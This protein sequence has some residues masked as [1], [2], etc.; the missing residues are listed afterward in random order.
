MTYY[1]VLEISETA[2]E[3]VVRVAYKALAKKYHPDVFCGDAKEAEEK[4]K[5][6]NV[7]F[8]VLS[9]SKKRKQYDDYLRNKRNAPTLHQRTD[10]NVNHPPRKSKKVKKEFKYPSSTKSGLIIG[11]LL[12][13]IL[14]QQIGTY[15]EHPQLF[16]VAIL[17]GIVEFCFTCVISM[18]APILIAIIKSNI[19]PKKIKIVCALN[20]IAVYCI[21]LVLYVCEV[22]PAMFIGWVVAVLYYFVNK[23]IVL[24]IN[25]HSF[26]K[27]AAIRTVL[28]TVAILVFAVV[29][30]AI[31][32][33]SSIQRSSADNQLSNNTFQNKETL[34]VAVEEDFAPFSYIEDNE[35]IGIHI[36]ISNELARRLGCD[37]KFV[38][39]NFDELIGGV[40]DGKYD[41]ALGVY[42]T[43]ERE[44]LV[45][46]S[47]PYFE[48]MCVVFRGESFSEYSK[49]KV[50][51]D[52]M[53]EDGSVNSVISK[54][55]SNLSGTKRT[56]YYMDIVGELYSLKEYGKCAVVRIISFENKEPAEYIY[57]QMKLANFDAKEIIAIMD[58][59]ET[60]GHI[61]EPGYY[62]KEVDSWC[63]NPNRKEGDVAIIK[64]DYGY[65]VCF[66]TA[67][68]EK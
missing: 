53:I 45:M 10:E 14:C 61:I 20:S 58:Y 29:G 2:S 8:E 68:F 66:I 37:V 52:R 25:K 30:G 64:T 60:V 55:I 38:S 41:I 7:A 57:N 15:S 12:F 44:E 59:N 51:L 65:T 1:D 3:E 23:H 39:A 48:E 22:I 31:L 63:F 32:A 5:Q 4:M 54:Y 21:S 34:I 67:L 40:A 49:I 19:T 11:I 6:I 28:I 27:K 42:R 46:F 17:L 18:I 62:L 24:Q 16:N 26:E 56:D 43:S 13:V 50:N 35:Y 36:D 33:I 47:E 9:D